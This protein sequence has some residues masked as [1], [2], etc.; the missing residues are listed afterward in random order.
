MKKRD[1][2]I[3]SIFS[4]FG[5]MAIAGCTSTA[6]TMIDEEELPVPN[7]RKDIVLSRSEGEIVNYQNE[8]SLKLF[9]DVLSH[10]SYARLRRAQSSL[11]AV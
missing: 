1:Y 8:F 7:E 4:I 9:K 5:L 10:S 3:G 2:F 11:W 6:T